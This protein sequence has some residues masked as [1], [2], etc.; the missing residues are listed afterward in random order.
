MWNSKNRMGGIS[1]IDT[2]TYPLVWRTCASPIERGMSHA[3]TFTILD[4]AYERRELRVE[5]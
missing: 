3:L 5:S 1:I 2:S 4:P